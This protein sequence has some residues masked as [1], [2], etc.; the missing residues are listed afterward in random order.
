MP[1]NRLIEHRRKLFADEHVRVLRLVGRGVLPGADG[2][3]RFVGNNGFLHLADRQS[4]QTLA[5]LRPHHQFRPARFALRQCFA[6]AND[7]LERSGV[8]GQ[9]LLRDQL[10]SLLLILTPFR[11]AEND[12]PHRKF[13]E[14]TG[15]DFARVS[16]EIVLTHV[17]RA[18]ADIGVENGLGNITQRGK[19]RADDDIDFLDV[20]ELALEAVYEIERLRDGLVHLPVARDD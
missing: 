3:D 6:H 19:R 5:Q 10:V 7:R 12:V 16:A 15:S 1:G 11:V 14:H 2:P 9:R 18:E 20:A 13:L 4:G 8:R 17:L